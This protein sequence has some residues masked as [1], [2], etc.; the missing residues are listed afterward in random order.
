MQIPAFKKNFSHFLSS[1]ENPTECPF[2]LMCLSPTG[3]Q[4]NEKADN[5]SYLLFVLFYFLRIKAGTSTSSK[6]G[7][8]KEG[9][10]GTWVLSLPAPKGIVGIVGAAG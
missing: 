1:R 6:V 5:L 8:L 2:Y 9:A 7:A 3:R 4:A 10:W